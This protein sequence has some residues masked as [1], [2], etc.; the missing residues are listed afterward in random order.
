MPFVSSPF[1]AMKSS[2]SM[3]G[4]PPVRSGENGPPDRALLTSTILPRLSGA[5]EMP[6]PRCATIRFRPSSGF[7][8]RCA[9]FFAVALMLSA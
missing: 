9:A 8:S 2:I 5:M 3:S 7:P 6:L 4:R 1:N